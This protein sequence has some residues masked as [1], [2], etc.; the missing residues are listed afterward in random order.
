MTT[1]LFASLDAVAE[2]LGEEFVAQL[3]YPGIYRASALNVSPVVVEHEGALHVVISEADSDACKVMPD[4][5]GKSVYGRYFDWNKDLSAPAATFAGA[6]RAIAGGGTIACE[7]TLPVS[8]YEALSDS[9][10]V[11]LFGLPPQGPLAVYTK[12]ALEIEAQWIATRDA[13]A[14]AFA[15][16]MQGLRNGEF[17]AEALT[18]AR[19]GFAPLNALCRD[20]GLDALY[21]TAPHEV[22]MFT[23]LPAKIIAQYGLSALYT[24]GETG[25]TVYAETPFER[26]DFRPVGQ[27]DSL[28]TALAASNR[29]VIG[30]QKDHLS[31]GIWLAIRDCG[32]RFVDAAYVVRRWQDRRA[33]DDMVYFVFAANAVLK[34]IDAARAFFHR[35]ASAAMTERDL[36]AAYRLGVARFARRYGFEGRV[37][38]YFDIVHSGARTLLPATAGDYPVRA[39]DRTIKFDMGITVAD[40]FGCIRGVSDIARTICADPE[41][42]AIHDKLRTILIDRLIPAIKPGMTGGDIHAVGVT[43]LRPLEDELRRL[44]LLPEGKGVEGYARDCGHTIQRQTISSVYFLPGVRECV[45]AGMLGCTEY[46]WPIGDVLIAVEDGYYITAH[47]GIPFTAEEAAR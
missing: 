21:V 38:S 40:G 4:H 44:G 37:G 8:R 47:G 43:L 28:A 41:I 46:V 34:G 20:K 25:V 30:I 45:E 11:S 5:V 27:V 12:S 39:S 17:L 24:P 16:F 18:A 22:E 36:V 2:R 10:P 19:T 3:T 15:P 29:A 35:N 14:S 33:G 6:V 31:A 23:G 42:E 9:G 32:V 1:N 7:A 26:G 13:D